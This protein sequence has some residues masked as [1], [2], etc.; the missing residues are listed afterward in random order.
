MIY[1]WVRREE[2]MKPTDGEMRRLQLK[3]VIAFNWRLQCCSKLVTSHYLTLPSFRQNI[4][5]YHTT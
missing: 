3:T 1:N 5:C 4:E 2:Q